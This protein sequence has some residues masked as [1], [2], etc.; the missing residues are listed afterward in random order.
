MVAVSMKQVARIREHA[1]SDK[2]LLPEWKTRAK[3]AKLGEQLRDNL[4]EFTDAM[5]VYWT[6]YNN[7]STTEETR[8]QLFEDYYNLEP[9]GT[10]TL[11]GA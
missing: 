1:I 7:P 5:G 10:A 2:W 11:A 9:L 4:A 6:D 3:Q 8:D